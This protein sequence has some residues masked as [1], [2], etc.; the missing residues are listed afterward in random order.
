MKTYTEQ[1]D[2]NRHGESRRALGAVAPVWAV[3]G[4][5]LFGHK[6]VSREMSP[7]TCHR[8]ADVALH[9]PR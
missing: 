7:K 1:L 5:G 8:I 4:H 3:I 2:A 6:L 9:P